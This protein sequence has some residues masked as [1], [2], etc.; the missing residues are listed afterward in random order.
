MREDAANDMVGVKKVLNELG[1]VLPSGG[2]GR[3]LANYDPNNKNRSTTS[4]HYTY[5]AFD[6]YTHSGSLYPSANTDECEFI[7]T[8]DPEGG[9]PGNRMWVVWARSD[10]EPGTEYEGHKVERLTLDARVCPRGTKGEPVIKQVTGNFINLTQL[11]RAFNFK[12]IGGRTSYFK[13]CSSNTMGS[14]WWHFQYAGNLP[15]GETWE[16][17]ML[18]V[19]SDSKFRC[20]PVAKHKRRVFR[21]LGFSGKSKDVPWSPC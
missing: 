7:V 11:F 3:S 16:T 18:K 10:K 21:N 2:T 9:Y 15:A 4:F 19:H 5:M 1:G 6:I 17:N 14:E 12:P 8:Y 13:N 20:S